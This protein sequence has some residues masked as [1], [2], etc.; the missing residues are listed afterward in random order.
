MISGLTIAAGGRAQ[1]PPQGQQ[2]P[3]QQQQQPPPPQQQQQQQPIQNLVYPPQHVQ[4]QQM[5]PARRE[6]TNDYSALFVALI[7]TAACL[8]SA[9]ACCWRAVMNRTPAAMCHHVS[10]SCIVHVCFCCNQQCIR[11]LVAQ[12]LTCTDVWPCGLLLAAY[13][14]NHSC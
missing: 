1:G 6:A 3:P 4:Q 13:S 11:S 5:Q 10:M 2:Q 7:G 12:M 9:A 14:A 8:H